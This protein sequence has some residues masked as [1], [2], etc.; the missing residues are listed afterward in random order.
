MTI[1]E[2]EL[3]KQLRPQGAYLA[4][5]RLTDPKKL[6]DLLAEAAS[7]DR[8]A[9]G[10]LLAF[11]ARVMRAPALSVPE[12]VRKFAADRLLAVAKILAATGRVD[13]NR[14]IAALVPNA[15][16]GGGARQVLSRDATKELFDLLRRHGF[17]PKDARAWI[18]ENAPGKS[19]APSIKRKLAP[20]KTAG[21]ERK[22]RRG[23]LK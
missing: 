4:K 16:R 9:T 14:V 7:G 18:A 1:S 10:E 3:K 12:P 19:T 15:K 11:T 8:R 5:A 6:A 17:A 2:D 23:E 22:L 20:S 13:P 21:T